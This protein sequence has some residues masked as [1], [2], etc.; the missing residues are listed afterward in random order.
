MDMRVD[1]KQIRAER[2]KRAWSQE[3]LARVSGLGLRTIQRIEKTGAASFE[4]AKALAA[5][6]S[7]DVATLRVPVA[8][9]PKQK[10]SFPVRPLLGA[11]AVLLSTGG[12]L[13]VAKTGFAEQVMLDV[14]VAVNEQQ[15]VEDARLLTEIGA[16]AEVAVDDLVRLLIVPTIEPD[17]AVR[18]SAQIFERQDNDWVLVSEPML[19]TADGEEAEIRLAAETGNAFRFVITPRRQE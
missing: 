8:P 18:L 7:L 12:A 11:A 5:V 1:F 16:D 13:L 9:V 19:V 14:G 10:S 4:S 6:F 3:Q 15:R 2:E 17:G